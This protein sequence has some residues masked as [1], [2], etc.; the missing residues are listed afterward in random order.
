MMQENPMPKLKKVLETALYVDDMERSI[1]FYQNIMQLQPIHRIPRLCVFNVGGVNVLLIFERGTTLQPYETPGGII[2]SHNGSG[3]LHMAFAIQ[4]EDLL[5]WKERLANHQVTI[6]SQV[7][8]PRGGTSLYFRD[9]DE[10]LIE[11]ATPG[12]WSIY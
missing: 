10:H 6:L 12:L 5:T 11:L 4:E 1:H 7:K 2:P 8:W 3:P 9:P